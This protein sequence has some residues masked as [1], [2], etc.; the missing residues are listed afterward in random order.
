[1]DIGST[2]INVFVVL[3]M[4]TLLAYVTRELRLELKE[5]IARLEVRMDAG[6]EAVRS[7]FN[8]VRSELNG[9]QSDIT[10]VA[11]AVGAEAPRPPGRSGTP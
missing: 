9:V 10:A 1:M 7:Q 2:L 4:G 8:A 11:L 6:F 5:D 3:S